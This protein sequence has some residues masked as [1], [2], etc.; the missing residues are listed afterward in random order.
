MGIFGFL[1]KAHSDQSLVSG[2]A[3]SKVAIYDEKIIAERDNITAAKKALDEFAA[4]TTEFDP[5]EELMRKSGNLSD[6][7]KGTDD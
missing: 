2:D 6:A 1:S 7:R 5:R 4:A 3:S